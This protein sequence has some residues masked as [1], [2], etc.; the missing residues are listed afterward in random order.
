MSATGK[1]SYVIYQTL[2]L[3]KNT[4]KSTNSPVTDC[5]VFCALGVSLSRYAFTVLAVC[6]WDHCHTER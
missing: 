2:K 4:P 3:I 5:V 6:V 1:A